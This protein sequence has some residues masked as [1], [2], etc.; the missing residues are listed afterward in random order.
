MEIF[1]VF[2]IEA[3]HHLPNVPADHKWFT[4][5]VFQGR[6]GI[7]FRE[8]RSAR[9]VIA[10]RIGYTMMISLCTTLLRAWRNRAICIMPRSA[11]CQRL[12]RW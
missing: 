1:K 3:A 4:R 10:E 2:Q 7:S 8:T 9:E 11:N 12:Q 6:L 5:L